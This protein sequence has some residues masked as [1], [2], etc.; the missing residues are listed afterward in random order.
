MEILLNQ[1]FSK[2]IPSRSPAGYRN[3][4]RERWLKN[5]NMYEKQRPQNRIAVELSDF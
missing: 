5:I 3:F 2:M 1:F 4:I